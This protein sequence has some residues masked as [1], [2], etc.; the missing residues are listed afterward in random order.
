MAIDRSKRLDPEELRRLAKKAHEEM[1]E[2]FRASAVVKRLSFRY[3]RDKGYPE[4]VIEKA[5]ILKQLS[6]P[7]LTHWDTL[8]SD[9]DTK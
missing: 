8:L 4:D 6:W 7:N 5:W 2:D 3:A 1:D 9:C